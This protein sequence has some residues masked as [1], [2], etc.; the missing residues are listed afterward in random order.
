MS[1]SLRAASKTS[2]RLDHTD[3]AMASDARLGDE[4]QQPA[5]VVGGEVLSGM[6]WTMMYKRE[7]FG[8]NICSGI[9]KSEP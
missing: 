3:G 7:E 8:K 9:S 1:Q 6:H 5:A 2:A 4:P